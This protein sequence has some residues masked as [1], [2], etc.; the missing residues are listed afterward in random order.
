MTQ[1]AKR[2]PMASADEIASQIVQPILN[3]LS[4]ADGDRAL[5]LVNGFGTSPLMEL[6][7]MYDTARRAMASSGV[8]RRRGRPESGRKL[9]DLPRHGRL[10]HHPVADGR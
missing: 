9:R 8:E 7:L 6:T 4:P 1:H 2:L 5:L 10:L 3:E